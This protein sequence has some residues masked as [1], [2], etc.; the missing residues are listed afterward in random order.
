MKSEANELSFVVLNHM[1]KTHTHQ[2]SPI[3]LNIDFVKRCSI[4]TY[5]KET[6]NSQM[7]ERERD[8]LMNMLREWI[9]KV[10]YVN[11]VWDV[12]LCLTAFN[13]TQHWR[14]LDQSQSMRS[15]C[16][17]RTVYIIHLRWQSVN[18]TTE[19]ERNVALVS[20]AA[21]SKNSVAPKRSHTPPTFI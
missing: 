12:D 7:R 9:V 17:I 16:S 2:K 3:H 11:L 20:A 1:H 13:M 6:T 10:I 4:C 18:K 15:F 8:I 14:A 21:A 19:C 5:N